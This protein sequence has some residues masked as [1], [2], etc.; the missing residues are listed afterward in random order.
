MAAGKEFE[1]AEQ[2]SPSLETPQRVTEALHI[3]CLGRGSC[4]QQVSTLG[5]KP[6][7]PQGH[8][9]QKA[10][11]LHRIRGCVLTARLDW[12]QV[13][14]RWGGRKVTRGVQNPGQKLRSPTDLAVPV[15]GPHPPD[16]SRPG[17]LRLPRALQHAGTSLVGPSIQEGHNTHAPTVSLMPAVSSVASEQH[18]LLPASVATCASPGQPSNT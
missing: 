5:P 15:A 6:W 10:L 18:P 12:R 9:L 17:P 2:L 7:T 16:Q 13:A 4:L 3:R 14:A 1:L 11:P 8:M